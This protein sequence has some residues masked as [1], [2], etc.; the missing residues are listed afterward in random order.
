MTNLCYGKK[1]EADQNKNHKLNLNAVIEEAM[2]DKSILDYCEE[3]NRALGVPETD[4]CYALVGL[5]EEAIEQ[6]LSELKKRNLPWISPIYRLGSRTVAAIIVS[7]YLDFVFVDGSLPKIQSIVKHMRI[8][9]EL[10]SSFHQTR[11]DNSG[12]WVL[13]SRS[14]G[15]RWTRR[16]MQEFIKTHSC[17][18]DCRIPKKDGEILCLHLI[19]VLVRVG[20]CEE[21]HSFD[22]KGNRTTWMMPTEMVVKNL[23]TV[24]EELMSMAKIIYAPMIVPPV[25]HTLTECGGTHSPHLRKGIVS[26]SYLYFQDENYKTKYS[27]S[28]PSEMCVT[29]LNKLMATEWCVNERVFTV[30]KDLFENN[31]RVGNLP[32]FEPDP[33]LF[34]DDNE[35]TIRV[36][37]WKEWF[38]RINDT[39]RMHL[40]LKI[41]QDMVGHGYF[42]HGWTFDFRGRAYALSDLLSPQSGDHDKS[43]LLFANPMK[44]TNSGMYWLKIHV[45][46]LF[47]QDKLPFDDRIAWVD[48][49]MSMLKSINDDPYGTI[50]LWADDKPKKNQSFQRLASVFE[51][52]RTDGMTQLPIG[53]DGSCNGI[54]HWA[55]I[56]RDPVIGAMVNLTPSNKP[57]DAYSV[58]AAVV[59]QSMNERVGQDDWATILMEYWGHKIGRGV[60][61][62]AVMTD[63]YGVTKRGIVDGLVHDGNMMFIDIKERHKAANYL[64]DHIIK[65]MNKLLKIPN[66][67]KLW[68]KE[69]TDIAAEMGKHLAWTTPTGFLVRHRYYPMLTRTV[70]IYTLAKRR[71]VLF[72][73]FDRFAVHPRRAKNGISPNVIHSFDAAHMVQTITKMAALGIED[74]SFIHDSYGCHAPM[75]NTM[76]SITQ[77]EFVKLHSGNLLED[78][79]KQ[80]EEYLG[81]E[82]PDV[83]E[84]G[85]LDINQVL[86]SRYFFH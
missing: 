20:L 75:V 11:H 49:N 64:A 39:V 48:S 65:A 1:W 43:L 83:P 79:K 38:K 59:T 57:G 60:V 66:A 50:R 34:T 4:L 14:L 76:R 5:T 7:T 53:M 36:T 12:A 42:Y 47:D 74:F 63:P 10:A 72:A 82:L 37:L 31:T 61:K 18:V 69:V 44:Q 51:L 45:A 19:D 68:L 86:E 21:K 22:N 71:Q 6:Y 77:E 73:E 58:V 9:L 67:G 29:A 28:E 70:D 25:R 2:A 15:K 27:G 33:K 23:N 24:H 54:Q 78:L 13:A 40:R 55:A 62:R 26:S 8:N 16:Q 81:V 30:M 52:F 32:P 3:R 17:N 85:A 46:N 35:E 84:T 41:A 80:F 56:A